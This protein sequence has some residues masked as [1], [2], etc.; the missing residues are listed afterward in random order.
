MCPKEKPP[1]APLKLQPCGVSFQV[2][3]LSLTLELIPT[4]YTGY[5]NFNLRVK[6]RF[7]SHFTVHGI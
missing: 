2:S 7:K 4:V 3:Y 5:E 1:Q 6:V